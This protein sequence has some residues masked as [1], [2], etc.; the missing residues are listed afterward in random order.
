MED[1]IAVFTK[2]HLNVSIAEELDKCDLVD[3]ANM[4]LQLSPQAKYFTIILCGICIGIELIFK[5]VTFKYVQ[6]I[7]LKD[8]PIN[9]LFI[10]DQVSV[11]LASHHRFGVFLNT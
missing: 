10:F 5:Y 7:K 3:A 1:S 8:Q 6:S 9:V 11:A 4:I 2:S